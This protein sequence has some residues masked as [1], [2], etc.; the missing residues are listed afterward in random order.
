MNFIKTSLGSK[1]LLLTSLLT[2]IVFICLFIANSYWQKN[3]MVHEIEG[4]AVRSADLVQLAIREPMAKGNN[5]GTTEKFAVVAENYKEI[6]AYLT[7]Y[8]GNITYS[9]S[10]KDLR[11]DLAPK[12]TN[13][14]V[15]ELYLKSLTSDVKHGMLSE[16]AGKNVFVQVESIKNE[17]RCYHCHGSKRPILGSLVMVQDV[18]SQFG[19]LV[20]SQ[21]KGALLSFTGFIVLLGALLFFMRK[22]I[23]N[24]IKVITGA[25]NDFTGG[26]LDAHFD[27]PGSDELGL[28]GKNLAEMARQIKDQLQYNKG[29]LSGI[30]VPIIVTDANNDIGFVNEPMLK[31]LQKSE[32]DVAGSSI[33]HFFMKDGRAITAEVFESNESPQGLIRYKREDGI[34]FPLKYQVCALLN[35]EEKAVG[36]IAVMVDLTEE[37][38]NRV[39]IEKQQADLLDVANEVTEVSAKLLSYSGKLSQQMN[40]LTIGVDTTAMQTGQV[41]TAMEQ[42]NATVLEVAQNTGETAEASERANTVAHEGG[43]VVRNTVKEIHMVTDTTDRLAE[44]L[45]DLSVRAENIGAVMSV[46]NDIAD[47]TNL[48]ALNAAIEAAR[49]GD[50]GRGFAVVA[51]EVRKLAEK[52]MSA[53][54]EVEGAI[55]LI[56]QSTKK[57]VSEMSD[58][59]ERVRKTVTMAEGAGG[60]LEAIVK[61]SET[62]ADMV[63]A[64][65]TAAEEQSATSDEVNNSVTEINNLSQTLSQGILNANGGIQE[66]AEIAKHLSE[67]VSKFK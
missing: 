5:K 16:I 47:Q 25:T 45:K 27:V 36:A 54:D 43:D 61:E 64:I 41:A 9:T 63:R 65:A 32:S 13:P 23:V 49:A 12:F 26:N 67:L 8:K 15:Q 2:A 52:T 30:T 17:K 40:E 66:V 57:V 6:N 11:S 50:A 60:V 59:R 51:D 1:V 31:I 20:N 55:N 19:A 46:I 14:D 29:V 24:R 44:L 35:A 3:A 21:I 34:E 22:S 58:A 10:Q 4:A 39:R 48:L 53:T 56:Q 7:N 18:S 33:G 62:I 38:E 37:E 28:L 42:M